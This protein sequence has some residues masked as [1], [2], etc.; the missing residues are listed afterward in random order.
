MSK[1][2]ERDTI[3]KI[4]SSYLNIQ[5]DKKGRT[6][7]RVDARNLYYKLCKE[8]IFMSNR[9]I[10]ERVRRDPATVIHGIRAINDLITYDHDTENIYLTLRKKC[11]N[12]LTLSNP[13]EKYLGRE[14]IFQHQV[15]E[16]LKTKYPGVYAI[17]VP[18]EGKRS[19]FER[20][21][22][23][24]LGGQAGIPDILIFFS[25][26]NYNGLAIELKVAYNKPTENQLIAM[27]NLKKSN[28]KVH[29]LNDYEETIKIIDDYL[30]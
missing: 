28:W 6:R 10:G 17:H 12:E 11:L 22:F 2:E 29:W 8:F 25:N 14:D 23:K 3:Y 19:P 9:A 24:Y 30:Q 1:Y 15:M 18:N 7:D 26:K 20:F 16:Y 27:A 5:F 13:F 21:K 4:V